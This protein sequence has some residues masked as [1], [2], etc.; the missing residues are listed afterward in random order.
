[1]NR[2]SVHLTDQQA[3]AISD[4]RRES[5]SSDSHPEL[6]ESEVIRQLI[7]H[8][9][10]ESELSDLVGEAELI[11]YRR[12]RFRESEGWLTNMR[13]GF[14][15][16]VADQFKNRFEGGWNPDELGQFAKNMKRDARMLWPDQE[17]ER[18]RQEH[19][20]YVQRV[21]E[22]A[23]E[24]TE[25]SD[26][27]PLDPDSLFSEHAGVRDGSQ[28][29]TV[30][31]SR[32]SDRFESLVEAA[33]NRLD[34]LRENHGTNPDMDALADSIAREFDVEIE[35]AT[36]AVSEAHSSQTGGVASDD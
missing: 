35:V 34:R 2:R 16:R 23:V 19:I 7:D 6:S 10:A 4:I 8:G 5:V 25:V 31:E 26:V 3:K 11:K 33:A 30:Q 22:A 24:A 1:M 28:R 17:H 20:E 14:R 18:E 32:D 13:A 36:E 12:K 27:D 29:Q 15:K 9:L 21:V